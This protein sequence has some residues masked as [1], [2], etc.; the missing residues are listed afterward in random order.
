M[1]IKAAIFCK[2]L[3]I[4]LLVPHKDIS[5]ILLLFFFNCN[6]FKSILV[7]YFIATSSWHSSADKNK[8]WLYKI[9]VFV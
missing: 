8:V 6:I 3:H 9:I 1:G 5:I 4:T 2:S 7:L